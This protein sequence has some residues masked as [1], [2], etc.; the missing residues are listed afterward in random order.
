MKPRGP[1][2]APQNTNPL[3]VPHASDLRLF[4]GDNLDVLAAL[5]P[6]FQK[7][8]T[9]VYLDPP[10]FTMRQHERV[11]RKT[12]PHGPPIRLFTPA[13]DDRW[14]DFP[15]YL[16]SL[17]ARLEALA[18]LLAPHG[19]LVLHVDPRTS[20]YLKII[21]DEIFGPECFA[22]E[23]IWRY[24]RWPTRTANFQ[25]M[26]NVLLRWVG[27]PRQPPRFVQQYEPLAAS[28]LK[29]W[30]TGKQKAVFDDGGR[31]RR[32]STESQQSPG[33]PL[34]DVWDIPILAPV[35]KQ[36]TGYPTQKPEAL[37]E[38]LIRSCSFPGDWI[39][40]PYVGSGTTLAVAAALGRHAVGIDASAEAYQVSQQ[41]LRQAGHPIST[42]STTS[43]SN[44]TPIGSRSSAQ[45]S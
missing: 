43:N 41:R 29:T 18:P 21:G 45:V 7:K 12:N 2:Q 37:L 3:P 5:S 25:R 27:D 20:H 34:G 17:R 10:F 8:F 36:R 40:D 22:S 38:R 16:G 44:H 1:R 26:H 30:G 15:D 39:L 19:S 35:A 6:Q 9:L 13:F 31:R 28:T 11:I 42:F 4:H 23:I 14:Q 24:R 32:S 33:V